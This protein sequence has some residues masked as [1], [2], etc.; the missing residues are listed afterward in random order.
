LLEQRKKLQDEVERLNVEKAQLAVDEMLQK[1][2][3]VEGVLL[4]SGIFDE[5]PPNVLRQVG[6][7]I[8]NSRKSSVTILAS[9]TK[10]QVTFVVMA[11]KDAMAKGVHAG[12]LAKSI[13]QLLGGGGGG[14]P[15]VAQAGAKKVDGVKEAL[16]KA[17]DILRE[18]I[19]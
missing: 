9:K 7:K 3:E 16:N 15:D 6:D 17:I 2:V 18:M 19:R 14:R 10:D 5:L 4:C 13:A 12:K 11:D 8:R 1:A